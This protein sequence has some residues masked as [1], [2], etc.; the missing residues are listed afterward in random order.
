MRK[1]LLLAAAALLAVGCSSTTSSPPAAPAPSA[2]SAASPARQDVTAQRVV[3][4]LSDLYPLP[5]PRDNTHSCKGRLPAAHH[6]R[7]RQCLRM[8]GRGSGQTM[9]RRAG[10]E[11]GACRPLR[12]VLG[13][14]RAGVHLAGSEGGD[15]SGGQEDRRLGNGFCTYDAPPVTRIGGATALV[16]ASLRVERQGSSGRGVCSM[17]GHSWLAAAPRSQMPRYASRRS[18]ASGRSCASTAVIT[19]AALQ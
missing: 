1:I 14:R 3:N 9:V 10:Q 8:G 18:A 13:G 6:H 15:D 5:N 19:S 12:A 2:P 17:A 4:R 16:H 11:G 7:R